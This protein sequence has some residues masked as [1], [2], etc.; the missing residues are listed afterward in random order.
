MELITKLFEKK[1]K[2]ML[3]WEKGDDPRKEGIYLVKLD[4]GKKVVLS[5]QRCFMNNGMYYW[6]NYNGY[7][8]GLVIGYIDLTDIFNDNE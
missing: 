2:Q 5:I 4:I 8:T 7:N 1:K 6:S 3:K